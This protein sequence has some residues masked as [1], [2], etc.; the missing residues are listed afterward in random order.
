MF[1]GLAARRTS[2]A[3]MNAGWCRHRDGLPTAARSSR[4]SSE[5]ASGR[6]C[7]TAACPPHQRPG[8]RNAIS[9]P[10][11][12]HPRLKTGA[13]PSGRKVIGTVNNCAGGITPWG[14]YLMAEENFH[15]YFIG[16]LDGH[17]EQATTRATAS[18]RRY[19]WARFHERFDINAEPNEANRFGWIVEVDPLDP[20]STPVKRTALGRFKHEGAESIVNQRRPAGRLLR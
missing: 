11:A 3:R 16:D 2:N 1:P 10:A 14:T 6:W 4:S 15:Y 17:P 9:G 13:D 18:R 8:H 7:R 19:A 20:T 5:T 12:G